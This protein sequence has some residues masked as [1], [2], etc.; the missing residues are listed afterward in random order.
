M[1]RTYSCLFSCAFPC[2]NLVQG[3]WLLR[4]AVLICQE[5]LPTD[6][7]YLYL[8]FKGTVTISFGLIYE[9]VWSHH[10]RAITRDV[11]S[12][13]NSVIRNYQSFRVAVLSTYHAHF[14]NLN[15][16]VIVL[17]IRPKVRGFK[18][19]REQWL[20]RSIKNRST[21]SFGREVKQS[22]P[23]CKILQHVKDP[24]GYEQRYRQ[25][26]PTFLAT[27]LPASLPGVSAATRAEKSGEWIKND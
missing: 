26:S 12:K 15:V 17:A 13:R 6:L 10:F 4:T 24:C 3:I 21:T 19:G 1:C 22:A 11:C 18:P 7:W 14:S 2:T 16:M 9:P 8:M 5:L 25:N 27:L 20:L 23:C